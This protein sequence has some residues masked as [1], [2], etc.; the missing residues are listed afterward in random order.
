VK[1]ALKI[2]FVL[3]D[4]LDTA[5]GV[6]QYIL[7]LGSWLSGQGHDVHYLVGETKRTDMVQVY[8]LSRNVHLRFNNN[9]MS[10]P[11]PASRQ[12]ISELLK[13][14]QF[15][16]L[17]IQMP[18]SPWLGGR[19][20]QAAGRH[21]AVIGT[22]HVAPAS[23][24]VTV[25][26]H[27]LRAWSRTSLRRIDMVISV[28]ST[29]QAFAAQT[30]HIRSNIIPLA[31]E[32]DRFHVTADSA[33]S[34]HEPVTVAF[35]GR[36]VE[37]KGCQD[38]LAAFAVIKRNQL[39]KTLYK[40]KIGGTGPLNVTLKRYVD[41][42]QLSEIVSFEGYIA[43]EDK[44]RFLHSADI[45]AF[46]SISGESFGIVL[47][48]GMAS[49]VAVLGADNPGYHSVLEQFPEALFKPRDPNM[50]AQK[51]TV[52]IDDVHLRQDLQHR[53]YAVVKSYDVSVVGPQVVDAYK[54]A[55]RQRQSQEIM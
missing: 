27:M 24:L 47:L 22:F 21:T 48:E 17:H 13:R 55:L 52:Y 25:A 34:K 20:V 38:L 40:L 49:G 15:D 51:L 3:D 53:Q 32:L 50:L 43:E 7:T 2:G 33:R 9:R 35:L 6:Q 28:S 39:T 30:F 8:S 26:N 31:V 12:V 37:R 36:L 29:A 16:I 42:H 18:Y 14:E 5:D 46:P 10:V 44:A 11:L 1:Q 41:N 19:I 4:S 54:A 23:T 45:A